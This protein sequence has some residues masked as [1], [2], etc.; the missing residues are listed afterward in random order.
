MSAIKIIRQVGEC[1]DT[2][3][4]LQIQH[5]ETVELQLLGNL[6]TRLC[7][8]KTTDELTVVFFC[9]V[10]NRH[11]RDTEFNTV[12]AYYLQLQSSTVQT[13][14]GTRAGTAAYVAIVTIQ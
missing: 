2:W 10:H 1:A 11:R 4:K 6:P 3:Y 5:T 8:S 7:E 13:K 14:T 9:D 12:P